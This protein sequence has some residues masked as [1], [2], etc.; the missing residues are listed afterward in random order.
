MEYN[1]HTI[2]GVEGM[3]YEEKANL[4][5]K[6]VTPRTT[7]NDIRLNTIA[8]KFAEAK[9]SEYLA[10]VDMKDSDI[11][12]QDKLRYYNDVNK[13][14]VLAERIANTNKEMAYKS[15][16]QNQQIQAAKD[17]EYAQLQTNLLR[18]KGAANL[19]ET[20]SIR[21]MVYNSMN[22][23]VSNRTSGDVLNDAYKKLDEPNKLK[24]ESLKYDA[25]HAETPIEK[26]AALKELYKLLGL[27]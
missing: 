5:N 15:D 10:G 9:K 14:I 3:S 8:D 23:Y 18:E 16:V 4:E 7:T 27:I 12:R 17:R 6:F 13:E 21:N 24:A 11:V 2:R 25:D 22:P 26:E 1:P 20:E 19:K